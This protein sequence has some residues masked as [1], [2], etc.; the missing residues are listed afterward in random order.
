[1]ARHILCFHIT[2]KFVL[3]LSHWQS[4]DSLND[5][6]Q[7]QELGALPSNLCRLGL[8]A[9]TCTRTRTR[10]AGTGYSWSH[11]HTTLMHRVWET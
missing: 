7:L 3:S 6:M 2:R 11:K 9:R 4:P 8:H 5:V 1:M 10:T